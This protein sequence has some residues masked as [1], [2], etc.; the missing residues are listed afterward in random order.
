MR[1]NDWQRVEQQRWAIELA[2]KLSERLYKD[3]IASSS[4]NAEFAA[5]VMS[6]VLHDCAG[7]LR[8]LVGEDT[9]TDVVMNILRELNQSVVSNRIAQE[10]AEDNQETVH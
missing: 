6:E 4:D 3:V 9:T 1:H 2:F 10:E 8:T 5:E 7:Y